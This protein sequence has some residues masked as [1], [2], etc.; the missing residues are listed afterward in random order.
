MVEVGQQGLENSVTW[1][2][3]EVSVGSKNVKEREEETASSGAPF[4]SLP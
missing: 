2:D 1:S 4:T 3:L